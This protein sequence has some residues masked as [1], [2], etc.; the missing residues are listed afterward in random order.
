[1]DNDCEL[2]ALRRE[3]DVVNQR[4]VTVLHERARLVRRI[5]VYKQAS[6]MG[7]VDAAREQAMLAELLRGLP[8]DGFSAEAL[9][10]ILRAVFAASRDVVREP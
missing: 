4:L 2:H 10:T 7:V 8:A 3:V 1:M 6:G 5:C 9:T